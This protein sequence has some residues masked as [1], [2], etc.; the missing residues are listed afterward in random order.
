MQRDV[1]VGDLRLHQLKRAD[2]FAELLAFAQVRDD[3]I[4]AGL[5]D[6][7]LQPGEHHALVIEPAHQ[8]AHAAMQRPH[9]PLFGD[10]AIVEH[11]LSSGAAAHPHLVDL[12]ANA[13][14]LVVLLD[15]EGGDPARS[16]FGRGLGI[17]HQGIGAGGVGDP[18]LGA[19]EQEPALC[20]IGAQLHRDNI[21]SRARFGHR[22]AADMFAADQLGQVPCLLLV[23]APAADLVD[24]QVA[25]RAIAEPDRGAGPADFLYRDD[26]VEIAEPQPAPFFLHGDPVQPQLAH[27]RP[28]LV[29][30]E[31]VL[32]VSARGQRRDLLIGKAARRLADHHG[33]FG[34]GEIEVGGG[35]HGNSSWAF[36][37]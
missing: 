24:A 33:A 32:G 31:P 27:R 21:R 18:E 23:I 5:H 12:L 15:Q 35:A 14:A 26:M 7:E 20:S 10:E 30:R 1:H 36:S 29:A 22:Q 28:Q 37:A 13:E 34:Q 17:D 2:R 9:D 16:G 19:V 8:H 3:H 4:E 11:Q 6:A 25:V